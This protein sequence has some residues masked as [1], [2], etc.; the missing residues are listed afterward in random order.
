MKVRLFF[1][2]LIVGTS[3]VVS[4]CGVSKEAHAALEEDLASTE[5]KLADAQSRYNS[6]N[7][8]Y[9]ALAREH[10][11][12]VTDSAP[13][14]KLNE[15]EQEAAIKLAGRENEIK[16]LEDIKSKLQS[17]ISQLE[18]KIKNLKSDVIKITGKEKKYPAGYFTVGVDIP[19]GRYKIFG[20]SS[21]FVVHNAGGRLRVNIILGKSYG[22]K[23]YIY[24]F[25]E[26]DQV[27]AES[28]FKL[29]PVQ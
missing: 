5:T 16:E 9:D 11:Q 8:Q 29:V 18:T 25:E 19:P 24:T 4:G 7:E 12:Y 1:I 22:V 20:G 17:E 2:V 14:L 21:N 10:D 3:L 26:E 27:Q 13:F 15:T 23:E 28:T 6:L